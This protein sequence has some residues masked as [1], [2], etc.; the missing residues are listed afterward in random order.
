[1]TELSLSTVLKPEPGWYYGDFHAHTTSS[2][3]RYSPPELAAMAVERGL[4]FFA[5]TEHNTI[6]SYTRFGEDPG[7]L[8]LPGIEVT[9]TMGHWNVF[10]MEG[11]QDWMEGICGKHLSLVMPEGHTAL[12]LLQRISSY[13]L[14]NSINHPLLKPWAW[15][16]ALTD[17]R[18]VDCMEVWNDP[19]W[20][21][22]EQANPRAVA[23]WTAC[24][25]QGYRITAIGGSDFHFLPG[26]TKYPGE[27]I[28]RPRTYVYAEQL[29]GA[30]ILEGLRRRRAYLTMEPQVS[31]QAYMG[32]STYEI[33][34]DL[35]I[36]EGEIRFTGSVAKSP[37]ASGLR[38][39]KNGFT[40]SEATVSDGSWTIEAHDLANPAHP[41]WYRLEAVDTSGKVIALTNPIFTGPRR[42]PRLRT[43]GEIQSSLS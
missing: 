23:F 43:F 9:F 26:D 17:L 16:E 12:E 18:Y 41:A 40:F 35:G 11:W 29:S 20:P 36:V 37:I 27:L 2:D 13:G 28:G 7:V 21:D 39:V 19:D 1:M 6:D 4:D 32:E 30:A 38:I 3:G 8:V 33:G 25:N 5:T 31:F 14:L 10:G 15:E 34:A 22:N 42:T 24:L